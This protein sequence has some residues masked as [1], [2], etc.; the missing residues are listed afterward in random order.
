VDFKLTVVTNEAQ[1][2][3]P[4]HRGAEEQSVLQD[5]TDLIAQRLYRGREPGQDERD[6][7]RAERETLNAER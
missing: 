5:E 7:L 3:E 6:W 1:L 4:V 2:P